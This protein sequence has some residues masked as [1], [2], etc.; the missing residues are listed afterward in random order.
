MECERCEAIENWTF[1]VLD[2]L[3]KKPHC[4]YWQKQHRYWIARKHEHD[5]QDHGDRV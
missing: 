5:R 1:L 4:E 2:F 3:R